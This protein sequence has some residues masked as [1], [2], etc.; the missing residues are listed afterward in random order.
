MVF[1]PADFQGAN[2][3]LN[4][5]WFESLRLPTLRV[6]PNPSGAARCGSWGCI[7][8]FRQKEWKAGVGAE[9]RTVPFND[10]VIL[11]RCLNHE[12]DEHFD[13]FE[14]HVKEVFE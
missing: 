7:D 14:N 4:V 8:V 1:F 3:P 13:T 9:T 2:H 10:Q 6:K 5:T 11:Q 12:F